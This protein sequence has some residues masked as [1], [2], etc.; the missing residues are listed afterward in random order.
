[1]KKKVSYLL[2]INMIQLQSEYLHANDMQKLKIKMSKYKI[3]KK[4]IHARENAQNHT[5]NFSKT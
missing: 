1:M 5:Q 2:E 3:L 4:F